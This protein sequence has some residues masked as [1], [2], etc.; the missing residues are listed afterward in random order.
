MKNFIYAE[1]RAPDLEKRRV[2]LLNLARLKAYPELKDLKSHFR[3]ELRKTFGYK[4][5]YIFYKGLRFFLG[6]EN[7]KHKFI[8]PH[9]SQDVVNREL[10]THRQFLKNDVVQEKIIKVGR[11][12]L[13]Y[14]KRNGFP[15][16]KEAFLPLSRRLRQTKTYVQKYPDAKD[17]DPYVG[18]E[19][20]YASNLTLDQVAERVAEHGMHN[21]L[22]VMRDGSITVDQKFSHQ[23]ELC[24]LTKMS[25]LEAD[26]IKLKKIITPANF[27][28]N[29][30]CGFHVHLDARFGDVK[31][32]FHNLACMQNVLFK[33]VAEH[34]QESK[35]CRPLNTPNF[36]EVDEREEH[37]HWDAI[38]KFAFF[39]HK[40][41]E[42]RMHQSTCD[43]TLVLKWVKLLKKIADYKGEA[44]K[45]GTLVTTVKQI[46][47]L[48]LGDDLMKYL[49]EKKV[50]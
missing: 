10:K 35:Y 50:V 23:V 40:T 37:A 3:R 14:K 44:L 49:T 20:E 25:D 7:K 22:R 45:F 41:I 46:P 32:M 8:A 33:M 4:C 39:K 6:D 12:H 11:D 43:L 15:E 31:K 13:V 38:S 26:L 36:D 24:L 47:K 2:I 19:L 21:K 48:D 34:R 30:S 42:I 27:M 5:Y 28:P 18:L 1:T 9:L 16:K 29:T 17:K